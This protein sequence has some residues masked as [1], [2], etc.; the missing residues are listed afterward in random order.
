MTN[1]VVDGAVHSLQ[2]AVG[3][4]ANVPWLRLTFAP[5][6]QILTA[7]INGE[8]APMP[9]P[10]RNRSRRRMIDLRNFGAQ[11]VDL[12][13]R[14]RSQGCDLLQSERFMGLPAG[15]PNRPRDH[16]AWY[17]SDYTIVSRQI[18]FCKP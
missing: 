18:R 8:N 14:V 12:A 7:T 16:M 15:V 1:D 2:I 11:H 10:P 4:P 3:S 9:L 17:G 5:D 6:A 13:L